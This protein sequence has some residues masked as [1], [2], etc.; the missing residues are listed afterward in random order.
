MPTPEIN[1]DATGFMIWGYD[2]V[3]YFAARQEGPKCHKIKS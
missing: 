1:N 2:P 3:A